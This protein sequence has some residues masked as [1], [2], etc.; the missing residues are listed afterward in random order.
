MRIVLAAIAAL[1]LTSAATAQ[2]F[3]SKPIT[4]IVPFAAGGPSDAIARLVGKGMG[5]AL[6]QQVIVENVAGAGG[7]AGAARVAKAAPDGHT[8][9]V[10]HLAL[11]AGA[12]LY[13]NPGYDTLTAFEPVG[14]VNYGPFVLISK[15]AFPPNDLTAMLAKLKAEGPQTPV[16]HAGV[17]S[18]SHLCGMMLAQAL[19]TSF[20]YVPYRGTGP[21]LND[22]VAG[23]VDVL[24]DQTTNALPQILGKTVKAFGVTSPQPITQ[25]PGL[26]TV[27]SALPGFDLSVWHSVYAPKGTPKD[28]VEKL[29]GALQKALADADVQKRF[30]DLGTLLFPADQRSPAAAADKLSREVRHWATVVQAAGVKPQ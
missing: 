13:A 30:A 3:P 19:G 23:Q 16:A 1:G 5:D 2:S 9:L 15:S 20:N 27:A 24:C 8:V 22:V 7:T 25:L 14:L 6:G 18:G 11:A 29:N 21:A 17:G 10:H 26:P 12:S 28:V 4:L